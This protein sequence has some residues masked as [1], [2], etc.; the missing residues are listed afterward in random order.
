MGLRVC[1]DRGSGTE[2][3]FW[4]RSLGEQQNTPAEGQTLGLRGSLPRLV[5][6]RPPGRFGLGPQLWEAGRGRGCWQL[7]LGMTD[8]RL[9]LLHGQAD[10]SLRDGC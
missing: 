6:V 9:P 8:Q 5:E 3:R 1:S 10:M 4:M 7:A 2:H